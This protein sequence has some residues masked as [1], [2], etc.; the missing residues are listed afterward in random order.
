MEENRIPKILVISE[1]DF[2]KEVESITWEDIENDTIPNIS[3]YDIVILNFVRMTPQKA[4]YIVDLYERGL[5]SIHNLLWSGSE[6]IL[7]TDGVRWVTTVDQATTNIFHILPVSIPF[8][9]D[10]GETILVE[11]ER[12]RDYYETHVDHWN[13]YIKDEC[14]FQGDIAEKLLSEKEW[15]VYSSSMC[16]LSKVI[17]RN[18]FN[19]PV[20]FSIKYGFTR[21]DSDKIRLSGLL[22]ILQAPD[23]TESVESAI[24]T[25][26]SNYGI[27]IK[28]KAPTWT[29]DFNVPGEEAIGREI[30]QLEEE[31][32]KT[33]E[34]IRSKEA[35]KEE[36]TRYKE[37]LFEDGDELRDTVWD[38]LEQIGFKV[39]RHD[40]YKEDGSIQEGEEVAVLEI[41]GREKSLK[42]EDIR[43]LDDWIGDY[44]QREGKEPIGIL[45]GNHYRLKKLESRDEPF[46]PDVL[47]Y[48]KANSRKLSLITTLQLFELFCKVKN[49]ELDAG[50]V[51]K[52]II[53]N[54]GVFD[55]ESILE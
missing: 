42:T 36:I 12:Y 31:K 54:K 55:L 7:I 2:P 30:K 49:R 11:D 38:T 15:A 5:R 4:K 51:R 48:V 33:E 29:N 6:L 21:R 46:P 9:K 18:G 26:L 27:H 24:K 28:S 22:T 37:L 8:V 35:E 23:K 47:R 3:E 25:L 20:S 34:I 39:N 52:E 50:T 17:A 16:Q 41:K 14:K 45:I 44:A 19:K 10:R 43:Q 40:E 1:G 13:F 32:I 53:S